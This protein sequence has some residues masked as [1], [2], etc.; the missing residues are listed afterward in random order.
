MRRVVYNSDDYAE[1]IQ[2]FKDKRKPKFV[3]R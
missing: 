3:G 1:G 2:A